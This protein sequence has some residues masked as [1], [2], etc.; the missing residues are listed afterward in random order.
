[1]E[2][3]NK[4]LKK[5]KQEVKYLFENKLS[6]LIDTYNKIDSSTKELI[7]ILPAKLGY[8]LIYYK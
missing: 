1:M 3:N 6:V 4:D 2:K 5:N 7:T 8:Y